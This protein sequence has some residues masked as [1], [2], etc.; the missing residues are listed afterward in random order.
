MTDQQANSQ[1]NSAG[2]SPVG[3]L[4]VDKPLG[5]TSMDVCRRVKGKLRAG[6]APKGVKVGHGGTLDPLASGVLVVLVGREA[7]RLCDVIMQGTKVYQTTV[8]L[9]QLS[10]TD[11]AEGE[12]TM[13]PVE[14]PP[15]IT[16]VRAACAQWTGTVMQRP[17]IYSAMKVG[18]RR[19]YQLA[20]E[21][22]AVELAPRPVRIDA[23][24]VLEYEWPMLELRVV[25]G[26]GTY[27]RSLGRDIGS[28]MGVGGMLTALRREAVGPFTID[29]AIPWDAL[30]QPI[31]QSDLLPLAAFPELC[32]VHP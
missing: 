22:K 31:T 18:G 24:S 11:D 27:I 7:T 9:S 10:T 8:D 12:R 25:C 29:K 14:H 1:G 15:N 13:F 16:D 4:V 5:P 6:G 26:K 23:I 28:V 20:R 17:P 32:S 30:P 19:S 3:L 2:N 21:D